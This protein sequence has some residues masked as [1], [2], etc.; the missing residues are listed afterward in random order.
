MLLEYSMNTGE[1]VRVDQSRVR[2]FMFGA[3][4][5]YVDSLH[6]CFRWIRSLGA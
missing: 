5:V 4:S 3:G 1:L 2:D 6:I